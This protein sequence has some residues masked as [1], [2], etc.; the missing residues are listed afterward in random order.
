M[1]M[2]YQLVHLRFNH[3]KEFKNSKFDEFYREHGMN[4]IFALEQHIMV[5]WRGKIGHLKRSQEQCL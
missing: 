2:G 1:Y 3:R 5:L 4:H